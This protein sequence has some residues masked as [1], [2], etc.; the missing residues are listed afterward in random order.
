MTLLIDAEAAARPLV[1]NASKQQDFTT[2]FRIRIDR[3][4]TPVTTGTVTVESSVGSVDLTYTD[5]NR[6]AGAQP[7]YAEVY[8]IN[9]KSGAD[10][11]SD[12][13]VDG[14]SLHW[15][16]A[17]TPG[18]TVDTKMPV[19][20]TW[21]RGE[22]AETAVLNTNMIEQVAVTDTG[23]FAIPI[24]GFKSKRDGVEQDRIR[25]DRSQRVTPMGAL[26]GSA[27]R[28]TVRNEISVLVAPAP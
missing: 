22:S 10:F 12:L 27:M 15:F 28:V 20:V 1:P 13:R 3:G 7:G 25:L 19:N 14:P 9:V 2:E 24:G 21:A 6:W 16:T 26:V 17:P 8:R 5:A 23:S 4:G 18:A 11:V